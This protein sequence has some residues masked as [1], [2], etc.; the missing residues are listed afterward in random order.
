M[1]AVSNI[2]NS[3]DVVAYDALRSF[4]LPHERVDYPTQTLFVARQ[5]IFF[6]PPSR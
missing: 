1:L 6:L 3:W 5:L 2:R 4:V